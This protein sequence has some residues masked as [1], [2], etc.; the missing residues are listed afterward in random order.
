MTAA[1]SRS[2]AACLRRCCRQVQTRY[3]SAP[4]DTVG[5]ADTGE[6][7]TEIRC[8]LKCFLLGKETWTHLLQQETIL[9]DA[10]GKLVALQEVGAT[11]QQCQIA[12]DSLL[13]GVLTPEVDSCPTAGEGDPSRERRS[14]LLSVLKQTKRR[15]H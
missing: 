8:Q 1:T 6:A 4:T 9:K 5:A 12:K 10:P 13:G 2:L 3:S 15:T 7:D 14:S 11:W